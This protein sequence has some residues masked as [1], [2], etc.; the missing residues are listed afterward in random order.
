[1]DATWVIAAFT[2]VLAFF[3]G[4]LW[5]ATRR[6]AK[7]TKQLLEQTRES[8][9]QSRKAF[10]ADVVSRTVYRGTHM[11]FHSDTKHLFLPYIKGVYETIKAIDVNLAKELMV[12]WES[13]SKGQP[14][15]VRSI[16]Q[17]IEKALKQGIGR[18][19]EEKTRE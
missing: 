9:D 16:Y 2:I 8:F 1:M 14:K 17:D 7:V 15:D 6:Y 18:G 12:V 19:Q 11:R 5:L 13:F 4:L 3:T 10:L